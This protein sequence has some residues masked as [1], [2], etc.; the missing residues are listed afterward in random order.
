MKPHKLVLPMG[1]ILG[2]PDDQGRLI[3]V[4]F[5]EIIIALMEPT[6]PIKVMQ[7]V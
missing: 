3:I 1:R 4:L 5:G 6:Q 2:T 7:L